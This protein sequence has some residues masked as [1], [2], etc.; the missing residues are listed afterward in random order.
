MN[1]LH[2]N[3]GS[4]KNRRINI[5]LALNKLKSNFTDITVS[6]IFESPAEGFVG[7]NFYNVGVNAK[8]KNNINEVVGI[9]HDIENSLGRDRSLP[10]FSSRIIDLDLVLYNDAIDEDLK[11]PRRDIL[12]YAFVLAPLAE[13]NP[14]DI[15]PQK[16]ISFLN[17]WEEFQSNKDFELNQYNIDK[18]FG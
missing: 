9:L 7:S 5:R 17:L 16:G 12:K 1:F 14:E 13:L 11:V 4:N 6:S 2:L 10:K 3:I 15:H 18:L 8:T